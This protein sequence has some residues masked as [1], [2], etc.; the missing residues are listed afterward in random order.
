MV[1]Y[2]PK[3]LYSV[4]YKALYILDLRIIFIQNINNNKLHRY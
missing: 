4:Q 3:A 2:F 1:G